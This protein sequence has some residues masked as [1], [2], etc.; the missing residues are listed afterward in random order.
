MVACR[1]KKAQRNSEE[2]NML[3]VDFKSLAKFSRIVR[4]GGY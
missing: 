4:P 3:L 2:F 1:H